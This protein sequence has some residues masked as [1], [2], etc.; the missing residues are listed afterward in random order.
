MATFNPCVRTSKEYNAVYIR[1]SH[2]SATDYIRTNMTIHKSGVKKG[3]IVDFTVMAN[4]AALIKSY[5]SRLNELNVRSWTVKELRNFLVDLNEEISFSDYAI[6]YI[7]KMELDGRRRPAV[8]YRTVVRSI[9]LFVGHKIN[10]SDITQKV[11]L[12]WMEQFRDTARAKRMYP[13]LLKKMY[14]DACIHYNDYERGIIRI[15][16]DPFFGIKFPKYDEPAKR[17][18]KN[19]VVRNILSVEPV[20]SREMLAHDVAILVLC[21]AGINTVDLYNMQKQQLKHGKLCYN[22]TKEMRVRSDKAYFE[23]K[24][25]A[26]IKPIFDRHKGMKGLFNFGERYA[27][28]G[29]FS[30]AVNEGLKSICKRAGEGVITCYWL[31]HSWA[32][33]AKNDCNASDEDI[34]FALNH[35]SAHKVTAVY[36]EKDYS[37]VDR[38]NEAV[39]ACFF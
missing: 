30:R 7:E 39:M 6:K 17:F 1:I 5:I 38:L 31:R 4:C 36:L 18:V 37:R 34:A 10:F 25:P 9:E 35:V 33:A 15:K 32:T 3:K 2:N 13:T 23:L 28:Y 19:Q 14:K 20:T 29:N 22:R 16:H 24:V 11:I 8:N 27:E 12:A 21:L 26:R